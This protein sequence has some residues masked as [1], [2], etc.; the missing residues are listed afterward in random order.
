MNRI[1]KNMLLAGVLLV[2]GIGFGWYTL[3]QKV[4][5]PEER[6]RDAQDSKR[7]HKFGRIDVVRGTLM[8]K[9]ATIT[10]ERD[11]EKRWRITEPVA[12]PADQKAID[13]ALDRM[14]GLVVDPVTTENATAEDLAR[15]GLDKPVVSMAV[16]LKDGRKL[17]LHVGPRNKLADK[18]PV[19]DGK[20]KKVGLSE[21]TFFW[22]LDRSLDELRDKRIVRFDEKTVTKIQVLE[23]D[24]APRFTLEKKGEDDWMTSGPGQEPIAADAGEVL[25]VAVRVTKRLKAKTFLT[26]DYDPAKK[27]AHGL[28]DPKATLVLAGPSGEHRVALATNESDTAVGHLEGTGTVFEAPSDLIAYL[29]KKPLDLRNRTLH[30]FSPDSVKRIRYKPAGQP[31]VVITRAEDGE[32]WTI[33]D[34]AKPAKIWKIDAIARGF[35]YL[36]VDEIHS[37]GA[38]KAQLV[39]WLI[40]DSPSRRLVFEDAG[41]ETLAQIHLGKYSH[42]DLIFVRTDGDDRIGL[43]KDK[44]VALLPLKP[45]ELVDEER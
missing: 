4:K 14:A 17:E 8:A 39:E 27:K 33:G 40:G 2:G 20:K 45:E 36:K 7:L 26:D 37:V 29:E 12:W 22:A 44:K 10:F 1:Q 16:E 19:T 31:E 30:R 5:T 32:D 11:D 34:D 21:P 38:T 43:V 41:G 9:S 42:D 35:A 13:A 6:F 18:Y 28:D 23:P 15:A 3:T 24:G 25:L